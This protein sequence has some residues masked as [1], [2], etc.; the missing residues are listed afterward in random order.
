MSDLLHLVY[1]L[2]EPGIGKS[3]LMAEVT[4]PWER[5]EQPAEVNAPARDLLLSGGRPVAV[6]L[7]RRR[8]TRSGTDTLPT[9]AVE[10]ADRYLRTGRAAAEAPLLLAEGG[11][12]ATERFMRA[13][14]DAGY[15]VTVV[16]LFGSGIAAAQR[17]VRDARTGSRGQSASWLRTRATVARNLANELQ[18]WDGVRVVPVDVARVRA[19]PAGAYARL[20][21]AELSTALV[22]DRGVRA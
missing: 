22:A 14:V 17:A 19:E 15:E 12:L 9:A 10:Q 2:G 4:E 6:E 1:L 8:A 11:L 20:V 21:A 16:Y 5:H 18:S 3:T 13:A 7:G